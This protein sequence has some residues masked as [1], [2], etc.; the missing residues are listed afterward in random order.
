MAWLRDNA[1]TVIGWV[2]ILVAVAWSGGAR[3]SAIEATQASLS[4]TRDTVQHHGMKISKL[5][6]DVRVMDQAIKRQGVVV[7]RQ[8][9]SQRELDR[10]VVELKAVLRGQ[11]D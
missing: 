8:E 3:V 11:R 10:I 1:S 9:A 2:G 7:D 5:E 6:S 4:E